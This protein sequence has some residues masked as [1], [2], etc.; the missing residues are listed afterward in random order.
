MSTRIKLIKLTLIGIRKNY[1]VSFKD[2]LNYIS[3]P[4]QTGKTSILEMINYALGSKKHKDYIEIGQSCTSVE[5][6]IMIANKRYKIQRQLFDFEKKAKVYEWNK[7]KLEYSI[8]FK[9]LEIDGP[10]NENSLAAFLTDKVNLL[11]LK[12]ANQPFSFRDIFKYSYLKQTE[13]DNENIMFEKIWHYDI[14]RKPTFEIIFNIYDQL[15][16]ELKNALK[17]KKEELSKLEIKLKGIREFLESIELEDFLSY[18]N[19]KNNLSNH[20]NER[21]IIL[22]E[23]KDKGLLHNEITMQLQNN[24]LFTKN[25]IIKIKKKISEQKEYINKLMILR[26]QYTSESE[27]IEL[28]TEGYYKF[29]KYEFKFCPSCLQPLKEKINSECYLCGNKDVNLATEEILAYKHELKKLKTKKNNLIKYIDEEENNIKILEKEQIK[30]EIILTE[31]ESELTHLHSKYVN[32]FIEKIEQLNYEIGSI[33][34][35]IDQLEK[36]YQMIE[37]LHAIEKIYRDG[38]N[39]ADEIN[40]KIKNVEGK[41]QIKGNII[42]KLSGI[43]Y[44]ILDDFKLPKLSN[45]FIDGKRYL[46]YVR[47]KLYSELGSLGAVT[48]I[49]MAYYLSILV[50]GS[51]DENNHLGLLMIDSPRSNLGAN[52]KDGDDVFKDEDIFNSVIKFLIKLDEELGSEIQLIVINNGYPDFLD[53]K[54]IIKEFDG[55]GTRGVPYGLVDDINS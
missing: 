44:D 27:R 48:L 46:P 42:S 29:N 32:P 16:Q 25:Q 35:E 18:V 37:K 7:D 49:T 31:Y 6:E 3:G 9:L 54:Y 17:L 8:D 43:F 20:K 41:S 30:F 45:A 28:I 50:L 14:K 47:G 13:I 33:S 24:I 55:N 34:K 36:N 39:Q 22:N 38:M 1:V 10:S 5:L 19:E 11:N 2:G 26:N 53:S 40:E 51:K 21:I 15:L 12:I 4:T 23:I 52:N